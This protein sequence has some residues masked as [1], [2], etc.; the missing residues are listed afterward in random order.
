M[1]QEC[2]E[3]P[4]EECKDVVKIVDKP[5]METQCGIECLPTTRDVCKQVDF[6]ECKPVEE[7]ITKQVTE[8]IC[9]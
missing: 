5:I 7:Q 9:N 6:E 4:K 3:K 2:F 8:E 1:T